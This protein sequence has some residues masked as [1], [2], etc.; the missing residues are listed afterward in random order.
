MV[1][2]DL[3]GMGEMSAAAIICCH[4][5]RDYAREYWAMQEKADPNV[6]KSCRRDTNR[7][8]ADAPRWVAGA[9]TVEVV[10][11]PVTVVTPARKQCRVCGGIWNG[12]I[13]GSAPA[14][15]SP[16]PLG[17]CDSCADAEE[18]QIAAMRAPIVSATAPLPEMRRPRRVVGID[19]D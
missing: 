10:S 5:G 1:A 12:L 19:Y 8:A 3:Q 14:K 7:D 9:H 2:V 18:K 13:F 16:L 4:C 15:G 11:S 17:I 6:C